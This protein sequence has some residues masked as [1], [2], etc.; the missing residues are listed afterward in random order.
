M[1]FP[2]ERIWEALSDPGQLAQWWGPKGFTNT[3]QEFTLKPGG[4]W[5]L[6][7]HGPDGKSYQTDKLVV[8]AV[9][10]E[11]LVLRHEQLG[12]NFSL[13]IHLGDVAGRTHLT[14]RLLFDTVAECTPVKGIIVG[15]NEQCFDRLELHLG[16]RVADAPRPVG[17][18]RQSLDAQKSETPDS[19]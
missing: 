10:P 17:H 11:L 8:E 3:F 14:W 1:P 9:R 5:K 19:A 7:M 13:T 15:A 2:R 12:H 18:L 16:G 6:V 4:R